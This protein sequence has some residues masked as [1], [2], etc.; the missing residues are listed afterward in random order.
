MSQPAKNE[1]VGDTYA[2]GYYNQDTDGLFHHIGNGTTRKHIAIYPASGNAGMI[3]GFRTCRAWNHTWSE[4]KLT[5]GSSRGSIRVEYAPGLSYPHLFYPQ[6]VDAWYCNGGVFDFV[7]TVPPLPSS[8]LINATEQA[9]LNKL[10]DQDVHLGNFIAE[11]D[12]TFKMFVEAAR[13]IAGSVNNFRKANPVLWLKAFATQ[14]G[15]F[16]SKKQQALIPKK[17]LELQYGWKPTMSDL[18]GAIHHLSR[19]NRFQ[20]PYVFVKAHKRNTADGTPISRQLQGGAAPGYL[21]GNPGCVIQTLD[22]QD[23]WVQLVYALRNPYLA[24]LSSLG[25]INPAEIA[26]EL[27][28]LSFVVDW[29][30]PISSWLSALTADAGYDFLT[31]SLSLKSVRK[32]GASY[33]TGSHPPS[34]PVPGNP[35]QSYLYTYPSIPTISGEIGQFERRCYGSAPVPGLYVKNPLSFDHVANAMSL[36]AQAFR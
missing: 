27:T 23:C 13:Y 32:P 33:E 9:A 2:F 3:A 12:K 25:L 15:G 21:A 22:V 35:S 7:M 5:G 36:L 28:H 6:D 16:L 10:K 31:G 8:N 24:E 11:A 30:L 17:W 14:R 26:W 29:F 34:S 18:Y 1:N 20:R 4:Q 19:R